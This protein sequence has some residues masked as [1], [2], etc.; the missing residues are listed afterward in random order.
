MRAVI[1][2]AALALPLA[3]AAQAQPFKRTELLDQPYPAGF[4]TVT[5]RT[6]IQPGAQ[7]PSHIHPGLEMAYILDGQGALR[8]QGQAERTVKP[9]DSEVMPVKTPHAMTNTGPGELVILSTYVLEA[10]QP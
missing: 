7:V 8:I 6:V 5:V 2:A 4:H 1:L 3:G 9:G 10:G